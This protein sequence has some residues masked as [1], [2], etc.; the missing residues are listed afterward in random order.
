MLLSSDTDTSPG[1]KEDIE[2]LEWALEK[3]LRVRTGTGPSKKDSNKQSAPRKEPGTAVV[4]SKEGTQATAASKG[5]QT[6]TR[7]TS[8]SARKEHKKPGTSVSSVLGSKSSESH[9]P[10]QSKTKINRHII[11]N[12]PMSSAGI[13]HH[14]VA[15]KSG[16]RAVSASGTLDPGQ[17]HTSALHSKYRT[18]RSNMLSGKAAAICTPSSNN[19]VPISHTEESGDQSVP[20]QNGYVFTQPGP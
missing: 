10:G 1:E 17:L 11:Q 7:S 8:K 3:A 13:V 12:C 4:T 15:R 16:N 6:T 19:T 14:Q 2:L 20:P 18:I 9:N 5:N